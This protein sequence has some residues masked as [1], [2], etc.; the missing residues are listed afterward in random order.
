MNE[1]VLKSLIDIKI[2][3]QEIDCFF[4][5]EDFLSINIKVI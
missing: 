1:K 3:L 5:Q 2:A 4:L